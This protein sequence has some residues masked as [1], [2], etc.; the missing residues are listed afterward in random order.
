MC[1]VE[2]FAS[3]NVGIWERFDKGSQRETLVVAPVDKTAE[4]FQILQRLSVCLTTL[5]LSKYP[6]P[7][8]GIEIIGK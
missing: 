2:G 7:V 4:F 1:R 8:Q 5:S 3:V 6:D